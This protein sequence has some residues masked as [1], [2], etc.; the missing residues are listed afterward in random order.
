[1]LDTFKSLFFSIYGCFVILAVF[2][3]SLWCLFAYGAAGLAYPGSILLLFSFLLYRRERNRE[4]AMLKSDL[5]LN[6]ARHEKAI[7][8]YV[9]LIKKKKPK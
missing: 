6:T 9:A 1:M 4:K 7:E 5:Q 3:G 2:I 8:E